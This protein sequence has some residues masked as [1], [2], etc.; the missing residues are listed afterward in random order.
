MRKNGVGG[1][2]VQSVCQIQVDTH[3]KTWV[4]IQ[5]WDNDINCSESE[6]ACHYSNNGRQVTC[7]TYYIEPSVE[8]LKPIWTHHPDQH[9][10]QSYTAGPCQV[11]ASHHCS[12][13]P[14]T[15]SNSRG[16]WIKK[17][18]NFSLLLQYGILQKLVTYIYLLINYHIVSGLVQKLSMVREFGEQ[19][20]FN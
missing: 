18:R 11:Q 6:M 9:P 7:V 17:T 14:N 19:V 2:V 13:G 5:A 3:S 10:H 1:K 20:I 8:L 4:R 16:G 12:S 15:G